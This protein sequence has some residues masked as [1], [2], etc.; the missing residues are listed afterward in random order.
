MSKS[1]SYS[2]TWNN[3]PENFKELLLEE[4]YTYLIFG[5]EI[6]PTTNTPHLQGYIR[7]EF[8][9]T[10]SSITKTL[11]GIHLE[12]S[13]AN[14]S[15]NRQYCTKGGDWEEYGEL[16]KQGSRIDIKNLKAAIKK[17]SSIRKLIENDSITSYQ[18]LKLAE[19][20]MKY[21][22]E[23][24]NWKPQVFWYY[25]ETG[26]GKTKTANEM[27]PDAFIHFSSKW[28]DGYDGHEDVIIDDIRADTF[29]FQELLRLLDR[30]KMTVQTKGGTR[31]FK[32]KRIFI[33]CPYHPEELFQ[34]V[35]E[36][37]NQLLRRIQEIKEFKT[38]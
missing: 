33:T 35:N 20:T 31:Q 32:P 21:F 23:G 6:A 7:F 28:W 1:Y 24:R 14:A 8:Q 3:Y 16:P 22:E 19:G 4:P 5:Y 37:I 9:R 25:G 15:I 30:Y 36:D 34:S 29:H 13:R 12:K 11:K 18:H 38:I 27:A 2:F 10:I 26:T 17:T